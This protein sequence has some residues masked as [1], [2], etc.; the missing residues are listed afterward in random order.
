MVQL[1]ESP[2]L[3]QSLYVMIFAIYINKSDLTFYSQKKKVY[4]FLG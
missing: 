4:Q 3:W 2:L 1:E